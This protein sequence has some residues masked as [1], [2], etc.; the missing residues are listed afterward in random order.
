M[1]R[2]SLPIYK[3]IYVIPG[4]L[5][6]RGGDNGMVSLWKSLHML[7]SD[8]S[9][10]VELAHWNSDWRAHAECINR[11]C[12]GEYGKVVI[13]GYSWGGYSATL[14]AKE[15]AKHGQKVKQMVLCDAVYRHKYWLGNW[16]AMCPLSKIKIPAN[17]EEVTW[18][19]QQ[20]N[21]PRGHKLKPES[22]TT[23]INSPMELKYKHSKMDESYL[24]HR[25]VFR[26][27]LRTLGR[28]SIGH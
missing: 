13:A 3:W 28:N 18:F 9:T 11:M 19:R 12:G 20:Q 27:C 15:L 22:D 17:V 16:R 24:Y 14:L 8:Y 4:F 1:I 5:Q 21:Y 23:K 10:R 2:E 7:Y 25:E 6:N 26:S